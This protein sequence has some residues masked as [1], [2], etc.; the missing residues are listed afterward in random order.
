MLTEWSCFFAFPSPTHATIVV[1]SA[2]HLRAEFL[3]CIS[4]S[5]LSYLRN[6]QPLHASLPWVA[7][8]LACSMQILSALLSP[9]HSPRTPTS[10]GKLSAAL[11]IEA[12]ELLLRSHHLWGRAVPFAFGWYIM[13]MGFLKS[14]VQPEMPPSIVE[15]C[16]LT[17]K[18][19]L[20]PSERLSRGNWRERWKGRWE[21]G[22]YFLF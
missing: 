7:S 3:F 9:A 2:A 14:W 16:R 11:F 20:T 5:L 12:Y 22:V 18:E 19:Q 1:F 13:L 15:G 10:P 4:K 8:R 17:K 6:L 21:M